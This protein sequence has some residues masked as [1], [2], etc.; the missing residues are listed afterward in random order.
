MGLEIYSEA[1]LSLKYLFTW[2][3]KSLFWDAF[4]ESCHAYIASAQDWF[5]KD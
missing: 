2:P 1:H 5:L 4:N 3:R